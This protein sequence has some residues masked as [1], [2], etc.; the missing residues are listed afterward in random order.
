MEVPAFC[1]WNSEAVT[2][3]SPYPGFGTP[4][5]V[6]GFVDRCHRQG[7]GVLIGSLAL[8]FQAAQKNRVHFDSGLVNELLKTP[9]QDLFCFG[10]N[11]HGVKNILLSYVR[12]WQQNYHIDGFRV[13]GEKYFLY[14]PLIAA[15]AVENVRLLWL[16]DGLEPTFTVAQEVIKRLFFNRR[17]IDPFAVLGPHKQLFKNAASIRAILPRAKQA[18]VNFPDQPKVYYEMLPILETGLWQ[19]IIPLSR[20]EQPYRLHTFDADG[21]HDDKLDTYSFDVSFIK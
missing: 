3:F 7:L 9:E 4:A 18:Y 14:R 16:V 19:A 21:Q 10:R 17:L 15:F 5:Q 1:D 8:R 12:F 11:N 6:M 20:V 2:F 13:D